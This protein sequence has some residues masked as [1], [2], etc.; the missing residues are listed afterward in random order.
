M[1][2]LYSDSA[3]DNM[4]K[5]IEA[6]INEYSGSITDIRQFMILELE[7]LKQDKLNVSVFKKTKQELLNKIESETM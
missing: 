6:Q 2:Q 7:N 1:N 3:V 4:N 5:Q